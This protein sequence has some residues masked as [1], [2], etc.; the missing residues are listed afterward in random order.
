MRFLALFVCLCITA[1]ATSKNNGSR[2]DEGSTH[3]KSQYAAMVEKIRDGSPDADFLALRMSYAETENYKPDFDSKVK[4]RQALFDAIKSGDYQKCI[5]L[6][7]DNLESDY[8]SL[9]THFAAFLC[10]N[11]K[12]NVEQAEHHKYVVKGLMDSIGNSGNGKSP[13]TAFVVIGSAELQAFV[14]LMGLQ[15]KNQSRMD[16]DGKTYEVVGVVNPKTGEELNLYFD[17][18]IQTAKG[19]NDLK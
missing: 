10:N 14:Q 8:T 1:C 17:T 5:D 15:I 9:N 2:I 4:E 18:T 16:Q 12:K 13:E 7:E 11:E 19:F 6:A 3:T